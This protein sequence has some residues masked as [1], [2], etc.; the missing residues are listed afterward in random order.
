MRDLKMNCRTTRDMKIIGIIV[1]DPEFVLKFLI[2]LA[3]LFL[4]LVLVLPNGDGFVAPAPMGPLSFCIIDLFK[5]MG[6]DTAFE[7]SEV[8]TVYSV[9]F[10]VLPPPHPQSA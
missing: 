5:F 6:W 3:R 9:K 7:D 8:L 10:V 1:G 2:P 4:F